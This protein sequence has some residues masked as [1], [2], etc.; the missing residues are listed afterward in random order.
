MKNLTEKSWGLLVMTILSLVIMFHVSCGI[1]KT[2]EK[3][4]K[5]KKEC[6]SKK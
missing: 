4:D 6:C 5:D 1:T 2:T 3:C